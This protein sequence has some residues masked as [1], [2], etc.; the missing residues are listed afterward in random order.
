MAASSPA[1]PRTA[2]TAGVR[3]HHVAALALVATACVTYTRPAV[4]QPD[5]I[6]V[7]L[8]T[9]RADHVSALFPTERRTTPQLERMPGTRFRNCWAPAPYTGASHAALLSG[10]YQPAV[11]YAQGTRGRY[12][13][14]AAAVLPERLAAA[15]Y[16]TVGVTAGGFMGRRWGAARG[17]ADFREPPESERGQEVD[18]MRGWLDEHARTCARPGCPPVFA[19]L[20]TYLPHAPYDSTRF[21][22][23]MEERYDG[24][25]AEA[26]AMTGMVWD[27]L[28]ALSA[29]RQRTLVMVVV[30]DHGEEFGER[31]RWGLHSFSLHRELLH[32]PCLWIE[33]GLR[34]R[35]SD[36][37]VSLLDVMPSLL[38]RAGL[39]VPADVEG[40]S[41][42]PLLRGARVSGDDRIIFAARHGSQQ[43]MGY[44]AMSGRGTV[45]ADIEQAPQFYRASD[46]DERRDRYDTDDSGQTE[47]RDAL[48]GFRERWSLT[49]ARPLALDAKTRRQLHALGYLDPPSDRPPP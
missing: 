10:Q 45:I 29:A 43:R 28:R 37:Q 18:L 33:D 49:S 23:S 32:V 46:P 36:V 26:D 30:S 35:M 13:Q 41:L 8:D 3:W 15:G 40:R 20:H 22:R 4:R 21:G 14:A 25:I 34:P 2:A 47:L 6:L 19:F 48:E 38:A 17:F 31:G 11:H 27:R 16:D 44:R 7:S 39:A 5:L 12:F 9:T 42:L 1:A 24:D